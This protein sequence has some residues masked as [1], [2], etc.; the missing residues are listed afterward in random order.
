MKPLQLII[1][2]TAKADL[3]SIYDHI[4]ADNPDAALTFLEDLTNKIFELARSGVT[5]S[6]RDWVSKGLRGFPYRDRCFYF[7]II[8]DE[9]ILIRVL[10]GKQDV[11]G[12]SF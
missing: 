6:S 7:R 9:M 8:N 3:A 1:T 4:A 2:D 5:G 10:H 12:N 11:T